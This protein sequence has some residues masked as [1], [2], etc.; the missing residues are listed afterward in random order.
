MPASVGRLTLLLDTHTFFI[1][2][3]LFK[4]S[5]NYYFSANCSRL[6]LSPP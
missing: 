6:E 5:Y 3:T 1:L 2:N 4:Y